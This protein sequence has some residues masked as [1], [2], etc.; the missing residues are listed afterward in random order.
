MTEELD[1][2]VQYDREEVLKL[3][4]QV[5][6]AVAKKLPEYTFYTRLHETAHFDFIE[7]AAQPNKS[8][9]P[10]DE[11]QTAHSAMYY[12]GMTTPEVKLQRARRIL[13]DMKIV[14]GLPVEE[15]PSENS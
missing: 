6:A 8:Q 9:S 3:A 7:L 13:R 11:K 1:P 2:P 14:L 4:E 15:A 5:R 10:M 12:A